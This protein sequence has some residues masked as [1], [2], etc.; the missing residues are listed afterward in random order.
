MS[1]QLL[2][3]LIAQAAGKSAPN[4]RIPDWC[5]HGLGFAG[6]LLYDLT[7]HSSLSRENAWTATLYHW[8]DNSKAKQELGFAP[9]PARVAIEASV[10]WM[11]ANG[12]L[13]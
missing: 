13:D 2:F 5:L 8:F 3:S 11:K 7:G 4:Y 6:D 1:I 9:Q 10:Q 12:L